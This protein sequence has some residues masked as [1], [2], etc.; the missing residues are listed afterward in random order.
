[1]SPIE[2]STDRSAG[3]IGSTSTSRDS[4]WTSR[5]STAA[6]RCSTAAS[7][8]SASAPRC[9]TW[10]FRGQRFR[11]FSPALALALLALIRPLSMSVASAATTVQVASALPYPVF[12]TS[13][14]GDSRLFI[15]EQQGTIRILENGHLLAAPFLDIHS[16]VPVIS[17]DDERGL[18]GLA[19]DPN[20]AQS[21]YFYLDYANVSS[22]TVIAR[23]RVSQSNPNLADPASA[24]IVLTIQQPFTNHKGGNLAFNPT[25][26]D[27]YIGMGDGGS[28]G[29]PNNMGQ[30]TQVLLGKML[31]IDVRADSGY[32]V[33]PTNPFV[34]DRAYRPEIWALGMRNPYRWSFDRLTQDL[35]IADVGQDNYEEIDFQ[36]AASGGG[37]N[38]GWRLMEGFHC[39]NPPTGC[40]PES[41]LTLPIYAYDHSQGRC[42]IT[43]GYVY[44]GTAV[45]EFQGDY[46]FADFCSAHIWTLQYDG[47]Q[48]T[49]VVDRTTELAPGGNQSITTIAGFGQDGDGELYLVDRGSGTDGAVYKIVPSPDSAPEPP[50][51]PGDLDLMVGPNPSSGTMQ[52]RVQ[53]HLSGK[54]E[55]RIC[56]LSG[57]TIRLLSAGDVGGGSHEFSW[58]GA[59]RSGRAVPAGVYFLRATLDGKTIVR[60]LAISR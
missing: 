39:Y 38:Y 6:S 28:E 3:R 22:N 30:D 19:F 43:G 7:R 9:S 16:L 12:A 10:T 15:V 54:L 58:D 1:M 29:D 11:P 50:A 37:Q 57:R 40:D 42:A 13:P 47:H 56:D 27:L 20:Y 36:P 53:S 41:T 24:E 8:R 51:T 4:T 23:Y 17:D 60:P 26:G 46:F 59:D 55:L 18:L 44:R 45:P 31:R 32:V 2:G 21:G 35:W 33:P 34:G 48:V 52:F 14:P 25:D 5:C 49:N